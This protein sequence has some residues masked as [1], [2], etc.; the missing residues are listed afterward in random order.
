MHRLPIL[1]LSLSLAACGG[2]AKDASSASQA[3]AAPAPPLAEREAE[4]AVDAGAPLVESG[5]TAAQ[6]RPL[7][8]ESLCAEVVTLALGDDASA[9]TERDRRTLVRGGTVDLP[10]KADGSQRVWLLGEGGAGL[11]KVD[12]TR[13]M[14][15]I[16]V[17][18]SCR[19]M[20]AR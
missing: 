13:A 8:A 11:I 2:A 17:G 6:R 19:T 10:R 3:P 15:R 5:P 4:P 7:V 1:A 9:A 20:D 14:K 16:E 12:V 18:R